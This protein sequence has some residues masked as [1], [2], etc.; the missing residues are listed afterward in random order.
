MA[1][2]LTPASTGQVPSTCPPGEWIRSP[3]AAWVA[4]FVRVA[5]YRA[6][7]CTGSAWIATT[8]RTSFYVWATEPWR[9]SPEYRPYTEAGPLPLPTYTDGTRIVWGAQ[10]AGIW[11]EAR[12]QRGGRPP[13]QNG[14]RLAADRVE[15]SP[16]PLPPGR[17]HGD[18]AGR[19]RAVSPRPTATARVSGP[20]PEHPGLGD[21]SAPARRHLRDPARRGDPGQARAD[22]TAARSP[23]RGRR[24]PRSLG[25]LPLAGW[26]RRSAPQRPHAT[27]TDTAGAPG[28]RHVGRPT[29]LGR[30]RTRLPNRR[31]PGEPCDVPVASRP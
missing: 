29:R 14:T 24:P 11:I 21:V 5:G 7:S 8:P 2:A 6:S 9:R 19:A 4:R 23:P 27:G 10:G 17:A 16:A 20:P 26:G 28:K 25:P 22:A 1:A 15:E 13:R 12:A 18:A 31:K 30:A 3:T